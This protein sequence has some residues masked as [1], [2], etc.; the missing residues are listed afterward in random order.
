MPQLHLYVPDDVAERV[1]QRAEA[2]GLSVSG[3][4]GE[5]VKRELGAGWPDGY[6]DQVVGGWDGE[7][8]ERPEQGE[9]EE[10]DAL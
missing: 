6:F 3:F 4:L 2:R 8:L 9:L 5:L 10:R 1:K 7:A